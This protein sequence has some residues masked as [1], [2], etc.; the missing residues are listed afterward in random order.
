MCHTW[1]L[2]SCVTSVLLAQP[3]HC[4]AMQYITCCLSQIQSVAAP[5]VCV[6]QQILVP[7]V[8]AGEQLTRSDV[9]CGNVAAPTLAEGVGGVGYAAS[10]R[11]LAA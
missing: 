6:Q 10:M 1:Q 11:Q 8:A 9:A 3:A 5:G 2:L 7:H 4:N